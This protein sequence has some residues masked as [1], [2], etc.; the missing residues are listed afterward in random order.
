MSNIQ[1]AV[2]CVL[3]IHISGQVRYTRLVTA[4]LACETSNCTALCCSHFC[5]PFLFQ[6]PFPSLFLLPDFLIAHAI[7]HGVL[8]TVHVRHSQW[9]SAKSY[10]AAWDYNLQPP[11]MHGR[12][13]GGLFPY[14]SI[15]I[16]SGS[17]YK[18]SALLNCTHDYLI[19]RRLN[20]FQLQA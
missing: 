7:D 5:F 17:K 8:T 10:V 13:R 19:C 1:H 3:C 9:M 12:L 4:N 2:P 16:H 14:C 11:C 20:M 15:G 18:I 6:F